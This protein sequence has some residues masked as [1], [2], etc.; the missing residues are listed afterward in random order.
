MVAI[1]KLAKEKLTVSG[2]NGLTKNA[3][4]DAMI[5]LNMSHVYV[6]YGPLFFRLSGGRF[7]GI[8]CRFCVPMSK[9]SEKSRLPGPPGSSWF[10]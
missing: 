3:D 10:F 8:I 1:N 5:L 6:S 4:I 9:V 2:E 7:F